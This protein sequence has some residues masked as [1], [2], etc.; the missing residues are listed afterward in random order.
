M[1]NDS[2]LNIIVRAKNEAS[3]VLGSISDDV[4][5]I[6]GT[7][8]GAFDSAVGPS[9]ALL[10]G[11]TAAGAAVGAFG[12]ASVKAFGEAQLASA[13]LD[14]VLQS[15]GNAAGVTKDQL[16][17]QSTAL[18]SVT[19]FSDEAVQATQAML[20]TFTNLKGGVMQDATKTALDM[21]QALG[22]D[23]K[24]AALQLGKALN[25]PSEGLSKL[26]RVGVTF[27]KA[28]ED[29]VK[30]M[31]AAGDTAGAQKVILQELQ[32]EF[33]GSAEAAGKTFPGQLEILKN[34]F[35]DLME[36]VGQFITTALTPVTAALGSW[37]DKVNEAGGFMEYFGKLFR[38]NQGVI[39]I[40]A[41]AILG[42]LVPALVAGAGAMVAFVAPL[43]PFLAIGAGIAALLKLLADRVGGWGELWNRVKGIFAT[44]KAVFME[45]FN[46]LLPSFMALWNTISQN[47]LPT[48]VRLWNF[49]S[50]V[51]L[52]A[53]K[54]LA[55]VLGVQI[56][57]AVW[58]A[59]NVINIIIQAVTWFIN[60]LI[61]VISTVV[62]VASAII[63]AF[64]AVYNFLAPIFGVILQVMIFPF[65]ML[66]VVV[67]TAVSLLMAVL[68]PVAEFIGGVFRRGWNIVV[69][70]WQGVSGFFGSVIGGLRGALDAVTGYITAPFQKAWDFV[71]DIPG[72]IVNSIANVGQMLRDKIGD[73]DIPGPLGKVRDVIPGF[74]SG[75]FTGRGG[76]YE[77]AGIVHKGEYVIPK[78]FV[79]QSTGLP[80]MGGGSIHVEIHGN[81][82]NE[83]P[84]AANAFWDRIDRTGELAGLGAAV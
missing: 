80:K 28:Q 27:S 47:L 61:S 20:L 19:M 22:M 81:V 75:G 31:Q 46:F 57:A 4:K 51:L 63:N 16:M 37:I 68:S 66:G 43:I 33:G 6:G 76:T 65:Q 29:Q 59:T 3:K 26:T 35:G 71:K 74:A 72:R 53:L 42:G 44:S 24:Q 56:V 64:Q 45:V 84:Q 40:V 82:I 18:Q 8:K 54:I 52:P 60:V 12:V 32:K 49:V 2:E 23:G 79:D 67:A 48:I 41:G 30:A 9:A 15:T 5:G 70:I 17:A 39:T 7:L 55:T 36:G 13:Q 78:K 1:G 38:D 50:P 14:A 83:T 25:D 11:V 73:W 77:P 62:N 10:G 21:A 58:L 69:G 34:T